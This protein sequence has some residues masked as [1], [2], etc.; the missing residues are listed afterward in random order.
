MPELL[1]TDSD[2]SKKIN[3]LACYEQIDAEPIAVLA[4]SNLEDNCQLQQSSYLLPSGTLRLLNGTLHL[5]AAASKGAIEGARQAVIKS[6]LAWQKRCVQK[7]EQDEQSYCVLIIDIRLDDALANT[8]KT[9]KKSSQQLSHSFGA[10]YFM[11]ELVLDISET[12]G[13]LQVFSWQ[14]WQAALATLKT[15]CDLWRF[16]SYHIE[17]LQD[18]II[19]GIATFDSEKKLLQQFKNS[20]KLFAQAISV[21]NAVISYAIQDKPN[22]ALITMSLAQKQGSATAQM[23][24]Q[25]MQQ[26][27]MLWS[28]LSTQMIELTYEKLEG[29]NNVKATSLEANN[30]DKVA[31]MSAKQWQQ[32]LLDESLFSRH[33]LVRTIYKHP[34]QSA[35]MIEQG[36]VVHQHSYESLGRHYVLIFYGQGANAQQ[37][38]Q[39]IQ[40]NL[41]TVAQE[42]ATRL[43][44]E[45][46]HHVIVMGIDFI[47]DE[48]GT[49]IDID[50]WIQPIVAMTAKERQ[51][52]KQL[53]RLS[54]Q[55]K[56]KQTREKKSQV[57]SKSTPN[58]KLPSLNLSLTVPANIPND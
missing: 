51:L 13:A 41:A 52:T 18:S 8:F 45:E 4:M 3:E 46:L 49:F 37:S 44:L 5:P 19:R 10:S 40:P 32:Q 29:S 50:L 23:Y 38:R 58:L 28:Q 56:P 26:A 27:A 35:V 53:Q 42:V 43:P 36:Y 7:D 57:S 34:K 14:D 30:S 22:A 15:P 24:Q 20:T 17:Q 39:K 11:E 54:Q 6:A 9:N 16:L 31:A 1:P 48:E 2:I 25:H 21:D 47:G 33:E 55:Q 12:S